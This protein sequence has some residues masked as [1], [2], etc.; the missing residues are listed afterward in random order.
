MSKLDFLQELVGKK[1][2]RRQFAKGIGLTTVG[3]TA[4]SL[5]GSSVIGMVEPM[6]AQ[7]AAITDVDILNFALNLEYLEAEFYTVAVTGKTLVQSGLLSASSTTGP[8]MGGHKVNLGNA[9]SI[10]HIAQQILE[11]E[12]AHVA[13]LRSALGSAAVKKPT[14]NLN[15]LGFGFGS[16]QAFLKLSRDFEDV[17]VSAY[18][19]AAPL[20]QNKTYLAAAARI[21]LT[22]AEHS[23]TIRL[24]MIELGIQQPPVDAKD[25][26]PTWNK[27][28]FNG[29]NGLAIA[30]STSEVLK[31]VYAGGTTMGGFFPDGFNGTIRSA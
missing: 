17:G 14:I 29:A 12:Q 1:F 8:T 9:P 4:A 31:I 27:I 26:P 18:A 15:A 21:A 16:Y 23:G 22:E 2:D 28:F 13:F 11:D 10:S 24:K 19:G 25:I 5:I 20:I 3:L 30:R 7:A 6:E